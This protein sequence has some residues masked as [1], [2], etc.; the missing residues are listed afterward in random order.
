MK[1][2]LKAALADEAPMPAVGADL[3]RARAGLVAR[4]RHRLRA[5]IAAGALMIVAVGG[6]VAVVSQRDD[7]PGHHHVDNIVLVSMPLYAAPYTFDLTPRGWSVQQQ[8]PTGVTIAPD[9]GS[10]SRSPYDFRGKLMIFFDRN[11]LTGERLEYAGRQIW[12][13]GD[14]GYTTMAMATSAGEPTG[15]VRIQYPD[16]VGWSRTQMLR[17]L[18][19]IHVGPGARPGAG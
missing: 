4:R 15:V 11:P 14:S 18:T 1:R 5:A 7:A 3:E 13:V 9:N 10:T 16:G 6:G 2:I 8:R 19:S 12:M 17:F